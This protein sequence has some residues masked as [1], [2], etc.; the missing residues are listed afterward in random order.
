METQNTTPTHFTRYEERTSILS[1]QQH[2][3]GTLDPNSQVGKG[4]F[5]SEGEKTPSFRA[6]M[7][8]VNFP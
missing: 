2:I 7:K 8:A 1:N 5:I 4:T 6:G 3:S